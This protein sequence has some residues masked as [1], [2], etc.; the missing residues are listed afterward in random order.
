MSFE[1]KWDLRFLKLA[2]HIAQWSKDP[3]TKAGAV[4]TKGKQVVSV[5]YNGFPAGMPDSPELYNNR[6]EKY[7][8]VVHCEVNAL[9]YAGALET[10]GQYTL[11]TWPFPP[12]DRCVVQMLQGGIRYFIAPEPTA[13]MIERWGPAFE[14][15]YRYIEECNRSIELIPRGELNG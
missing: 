4:I 10:L 1:R 11:Y 15:T 2:E 8:R 12:C 14:R 13:E 5:G 9:I 3:S 7:S 6:E